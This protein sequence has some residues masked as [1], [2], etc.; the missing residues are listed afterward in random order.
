[1]YWWQRKRLASI[2]WKA[3]HNSY[4]SAIAKAHAGT[5]VASLE[6]AVAMIET[7]RELID[8]EEEISEGKPA[9]LSRH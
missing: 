9:W 4:S 6:H 2:L 8:L 7:T 1:M 5:S 3:W